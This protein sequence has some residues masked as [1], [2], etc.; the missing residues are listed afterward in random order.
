[1]KGYLVIMLGLA[2]AGYRGGR[3]LWTAPDCA[4]RFDEKSAARLAASLRAQGLPAIVKGGE[5]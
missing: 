5:K 2:Y 3:R 4:R 1:M